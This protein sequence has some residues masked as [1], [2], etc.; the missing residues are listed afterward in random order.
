MTLNKLLQSQMARIRSLGDWICSRVT[1]LTFFINLMLTKNHAYFSL[2]LPVSTL[3]EIL[4]QNM[5]SSFSSSQ[6]IL[7]PPNLRD[8]DKK[9]K[10]HQD[11]EYTGT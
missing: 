10:A 5:N 3:P 4:L 2:S 9:K 8:R 11:K 1:L 7:F 6:R